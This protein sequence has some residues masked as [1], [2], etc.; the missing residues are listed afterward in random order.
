M[1]MISTGI[2]LGNNGQFVREPF[3]N[4][5]QAAVEN[6]L[7]AVELTLQTPHFYVDSEKYHSIAKQ[8]EL[9]RK[10]G[11]SVASIHPL[12]YRYSICAALD[13]IQHK[14]TIG[15]YK[16]CILLAEE[17]EADYVCVSAAGAD[18]DCDKE[19][20]LKNAEATLRKLTEFAGKHGRTL[21]LG[22]VLGEECPVN[23][24]TPV[25][26]HLDEL[27]AMIATVSSQWLGAYLDTEVI[28]V[29]G[30]TIEAWITSLKERLRLVKFTDGNYN[31]YR[32]W[33][34]GCLP[35]RKFLRELDKLDY[36]GSLSLIIPG[37]RYIYNPREAFAEHVKN[38]RAAMEG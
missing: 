19:S 32:I 20:L 3:E 14:K 28:S 23:A 17:L 27:E 7:M 5:I 34:E 10:A 38:V 16:Q 1:K 33:G 22:T 21:L 37:E 12:P 29:C 31:G 36:R 6:K 2:L 13:T 25:L 9:L 35:C 4:F 11:L 15:Y 18:Y 24:S 26:T 30:E 8:K